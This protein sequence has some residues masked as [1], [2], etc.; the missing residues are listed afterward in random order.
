[1]RCPGLVAAVVD[2]LT[3]TP[4]SS[5]PHRD[6]R[7]RSTRAKRGAHAQ[8]LISA[9]AGESTLA[10]A[11]LTRRDHL[12]PTADQHVVVLF[13]QWIGQRLEGTAS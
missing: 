3:S 2:R 10:E 8:V 9:P 12:K 5:R 4:T 7:L 1:M 13:V 11:T 6:L